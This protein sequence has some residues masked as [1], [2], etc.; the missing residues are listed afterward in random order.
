M[1][2][3]DHAFSFQVPAA[4]LPALQVVLAALEGENAHLG[5]VGASGG[6]LSLSPALEGGLRD[7]L[8]LL[9]TRHAVEVLP[10]DEELSPNEAADRLNVSRT[11]VNKL[12]ERGE[13]PC[14]M[15]GTHKRIPL[16]DLLTYM[17][18]IAARR[19]EG[20]AAI[21]GFSQAQGGE[22]DA[23]YPGRGS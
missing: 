7:V 14:R 21:A 12:L 22:I 6:A 16:A 4:E 8:R 19:R 18:R 23:P 5:V 20:L 13:L 17:E 15:V 11:F 10:A 3:R 1:A 9:L 2:L